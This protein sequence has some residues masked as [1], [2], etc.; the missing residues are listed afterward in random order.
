MTTPLHRVRFTSACLRLQTAF[1]A[2]AVSQLVERNGNSIT[3][4]VSETVEK[5]EKAIYNCSASNATK[6]RLLMKIRKVLEQSGL[7]PDTSA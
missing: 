7:K 2:N 3:P 1:V 4:S 6:L 5:I